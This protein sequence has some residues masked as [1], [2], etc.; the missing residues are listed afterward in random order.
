V[1]RLN[2]FLR[3][4]DVFMK[5]H[6]GIALVAFAADLDTREASVTGNVQAEDAAP[7][8]RQAAGMAERQVDAIAAAVAKL[9][10]QM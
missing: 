9:P 6:N 4:L 7:M 2:Q 8:F 3:D 5:R 1:T 10:R